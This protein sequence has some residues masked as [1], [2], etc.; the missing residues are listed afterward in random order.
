VRVRI[1]TNLE[2]RQ[3]STNPFIPAHFCVRSMLDFLP[4]WAS[5][6]WPILLVLVYVIYI[7]P[8]APKALTMRSEAVEGDPATRQSRKPLTASLFPEALTL[9]ASLRRSVENFGS[10]PC[11]GVRKYACLVVCLFVCSSPCVCLCVSVS[12][13]A[14]VC[15]CLCLCVCARVCGCRGCYFNTIGLTAHPI[16]LFMRV[17]SPW[18]S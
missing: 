16:C 13:S 7:R 1:E 5:A 11:L 9:D 2:H 12:A 14:S 17:V 15:V 4:G 8:L 3:N 6:W 10:R 18:R